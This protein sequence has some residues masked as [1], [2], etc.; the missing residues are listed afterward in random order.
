MRARS[1]E[2]NWLPTS[3]HS[4]RMV[5]GQSLRFLSWR[6]KLGDSHVR[7]QSGRNH[8]RCMKNPMRGKSSVLE[9]SPSSFAF[10]NRVYHFHITESTNRLAEPYLLVHLWLSPMCLRTHFRSRYVFERAIGSIGWS[11][12]FLNVTITQNP[13]DNLTLICFH[14]AYWSIFRR[15]I[16]TSPWE[17][18]FFALVGISSV[19]LTT[20][21]SIL[22]KRVLTD[23]VQRRCYNAGPEFPESSLD[24]LPMNIL[25]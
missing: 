9:S 7:E 11:P 6:G 14:L 23:N 8:T 25:R 4:R 10:S 16:P 2:V 15:Y 21:P 3:C 20:L 1:K 24:S 19:A 5:M 12:F 13:L 17:R 22:L 18:I